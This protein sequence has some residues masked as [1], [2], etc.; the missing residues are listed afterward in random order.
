MQVLAISSRK[1]QLDVIRR[2]LGSLG[3]PRPIMKLPWGVCW[4][5]MF[6][7]KDMNIG[8]CMGATGSVTSI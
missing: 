3:S 4:Q 2:S 8:P 5:Y 6:C 1:S 7:E